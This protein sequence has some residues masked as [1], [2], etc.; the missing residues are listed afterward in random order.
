ML[1]RG[2]AL[3]SFTPSLSS[4][5]PSGLTVRITLSRTRV[6]FFSTAFY[7]GYERFLHKTFICFPN[8]FSRRSEEQLWGILPGERPVWGRCQFVSTPWGN[9]MKKPKAKDLGLLVFCFLNPNRWWGHLEM[10]DKR[11]HNRWGFKM[12]PSFFTFRNR[13]RKACKEKEDA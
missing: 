10:I 11:S 7:W 6:I 13:C 5:A 8:R 4:V 12:W 1:I 3:T 2:S 9:S